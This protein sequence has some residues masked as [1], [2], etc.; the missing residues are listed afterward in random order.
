LSA[1]AVR[2]DVSR[3]NGTKH[4]MKKQVF[5]RKRLMKVE[6]SSFFALL[7]F[8]FGKKSKNYKIFPGVKMFFGSNTRFISRIKFNVT[9]GK[10]ISIN[11][12]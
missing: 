12:F 1:V 7:F 9:S 11:G 4:E 5:R 10:A 3:S 6:K 8:C 2:G